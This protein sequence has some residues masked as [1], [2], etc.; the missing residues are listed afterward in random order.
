MILVM[1]RWNYEDLANM[2]DHTEHRQKIRYLRE[3]NT[4]HDGRDLEIEDPITGTPADFETAFD[5]IQASVEG[6]LDYLLDEGNQP[7]AR[8]LKNG[9]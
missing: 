5:M 3:F 2:A 4:D 9:V 7:R 1:D 8:S 6:L